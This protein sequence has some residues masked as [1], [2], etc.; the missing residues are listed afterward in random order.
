[1]HFLFNFLWIRLKFVINWAVLQHP[2]MNLSKSQFMASLTH[3]SIQMMFF[4]CKYVL[5]WTASMKK[6]IWYK[7]LTLYYRL[8]M[9]TFLAMVLANEI[10]Y[11]LRFLKYPWVYLNYCV[12]E[13]TRKYCLSQLQFLRVF[14]SVPKTMIDTKIQS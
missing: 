13:I 1:M 6:L 5:K 2:E 8:K 14:K 11:T 9:A 4:R 7:H 10:R 12:M 3:D